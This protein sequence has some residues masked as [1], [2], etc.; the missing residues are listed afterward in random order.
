MNAHPK[1]TKAQE[2]G[3]LVLRR[4][5][6]NEDNR[7]KMASHG[8]IEGVLDARSA[9]PKATQVH[10]NGCLALGRLARNEDDRGEDRV[11]WWRRGG[12]AY[13]GRAPRGDAGA[14]Y[15]RPCSGEAVRSYGLRVY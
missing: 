13:D 1:A 4:L 15:W 5:A 7:V 8:G 2:N 6:R 11:P 3:C 10:D 12:A 9:H 14:R